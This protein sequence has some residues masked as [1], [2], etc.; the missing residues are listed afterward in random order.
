MFHIL[1]PNFC[2]CLQGG[3]DGMPTVDNQVLLRIHSRLSHAGV[4]LHLYGVP[5]EW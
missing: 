4:Q 5:V 1:N 2:L 3:G